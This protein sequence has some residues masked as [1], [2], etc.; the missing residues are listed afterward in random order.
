MSNARDVFVAY[1]NLLKLELLKLR[2]RF[3][4]VMQT[5]DGT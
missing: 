4:I 2:Y 1:T 3:V 5:G